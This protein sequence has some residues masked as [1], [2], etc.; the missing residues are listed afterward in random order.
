LIW[1]RTSPRESE[2]LLLAATLRRIAGDLIPDLAPIEAAP[3][4]DPA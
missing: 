4:L 1:R 3:A 2:F